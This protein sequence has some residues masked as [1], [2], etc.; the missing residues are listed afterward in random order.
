MSTTLHLPARI[1]AHTGSFSMET[2]S[3]G[4]S[5]ADVF[6]IGDMYLK[7]AP[8]GTLERSA[9]AQEYFHKKGLSA[10]LL[11][12]EQ[13]SGRDYLLVRS[14]PG[15]YACD[16]TLMNQPDR[17]ARV[18]GETVRLL[19]ETDASDCPLTDANARALTAYEKES[20]KAF[21]GDSAVL[22]EDAL[23]HGDMCLPNI[24]CDEDYRF[25]GFIDLGDSGLGDRHFDL[26][27]AMWSL[28]YNLKTDRYNETFM[29]AYGLDAFDPARYAVC[30]AISPGV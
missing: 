19:H 4:R 3:M 7:I 13:E 25:T 5:G 2:D 24:F 17:L 8:L 29:T 30:A 10:P 11:A 22:K 12:F 16:R 21:A 28:S 18:L 1:L 27:W 26:Y 20:G 9:Q 15:A 14:V 23:I 6:R